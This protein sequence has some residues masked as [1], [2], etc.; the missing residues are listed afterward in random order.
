MR[1]DLHLHSHYSEDAKPSP[2]DII[3]RGKKE[4]LDGL[5]FLDHNTMDGYRK[6][7]DESELSIIP[8]MEVTTEEGHVG[9]LGL[10]EEV[11]RDLSVPETVDRIRDQGGIAVAVHPYRFF[12]GIKEKVVIENDWDAMEGLNGRS[13]ARKNERAVRLAKKI[14]LPMIGGSDSHRLKTVGKAYTTVENVSSWPE[15]V[16]QIRKG[17]SDVGGRS[18]TFPETFFY[19]G[20]TLSHWVKRGFKRV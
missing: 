9:A 13:W 16:E 19:V 14:G 1:F 8:A 3:R 12:S 15:V 4:G 7:K 18:R 17:E 10:Q 5:A 6:V 20:R 11:E 2:I